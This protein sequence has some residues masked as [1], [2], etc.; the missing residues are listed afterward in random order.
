[1]YALNLYCFSLIV[2]GIRDNP[3]Y[4]ENPKQT[5]IKISLSLLLFGLL[6]PII[7]GCLIMN[8]GTSIVTGGVVSID[9]RYIV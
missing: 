9:I 3:V 7:R 1:M 2:R 6:F 4:K 5:I 8:P